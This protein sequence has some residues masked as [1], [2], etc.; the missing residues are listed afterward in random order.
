MST[1]TDPLLP[2]PRSTRSASELTTPEDGS[3]SRNERHKLYRLLLVVALASTCRGIS[4]FSRD[5]II[6]RPGPILDDWLQM[7]GYSIGLDL[8]STW[9]S[10]V[11]CFASI[12]WWSALSDRRGRIPILL[13]SL[14]GCVILDVV[15]A[16][17]ARKIFSHEG[18]S[19]AIII[20]GVLGGFPA[21]NA[22]VHAYA[23][24]VSGDAISRTVIFSV[25]Q[26]TYLIFLRCGGYLGWAIDKVLGST[27]HTSPEFTYFLSIPLAVANLYLIHRILP[28]SLN[29]QQ[30]QNSPP[31][32]STLLQYIF[33]PFTT[34]ARKG[35][36][37]GKVVLLAFATFFYCWTLAF[38]GKMVSFTSYQGYFRGLPRSLLLVIPLIINLSTLLG[39][40]PALASFIQ[41]T[42]TESDSDSEKSGRLLA[43]SLAQNSVLL[44]AVCAIGILVFGGPRSSILYGIFFFTYPFSIG[45]L[46]ALYSLAASYFTALGRSREFGALFGALSIW[47]TWGEFISY[48][49]M[50]GSPGYL[51]YAVD[52]TAFYLVVSLLFLVPNGPPVASAEALAE[53]GR[54][55]L[56]GR[57]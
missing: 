19:I 6:S 8:W 3:G 48:S 39:V 20:E 1:E 18:I 36:S 12:G 17:V 33:S 51:T 14:T 9:A 40:I 42:F 49:A 55:E 47:A 35:P 54:D 26:A 41:R 30:L 57:V 32:Q 29:Q 5:F 56:E 10:A 27:T 31:S 46:P 23:S 24:D 43:R 16:A 21:F 2:R 53:S 28:E 7:P 13:V 34:L 37:R 50:T 45:A 15:Y 44:A 4:M 38:G 11:V 25:I 22:A 52:W